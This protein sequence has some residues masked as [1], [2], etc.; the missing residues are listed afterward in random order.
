MGL[1]RAALER[2]RVIGAPQVGA[3]KAGRDVGADMVALTEM[4]VTGYQSQDLMA[5]ACKALGISL[6][7][8]FQA[9]N[10]RPLKI[11][12]SGKLIKE[13]FA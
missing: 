6:D 9:R 3:W 12:N 2:D 1:P 8:T 11:A 10:G 7:T 5:S 4:F 13:L